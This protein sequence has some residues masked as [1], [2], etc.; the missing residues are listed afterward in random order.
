LFY[1]IKENLVSYTS[2]KE[3]FGSTINILGAES[4]GSESLADF[5]IKGNEI[6]S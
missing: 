2:V 5:I 3:I 4:G 1:L 6:D